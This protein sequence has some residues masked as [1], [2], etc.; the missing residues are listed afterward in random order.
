MKRLHDF[1]TW[2]K[3]NEAESSGLS[4]IFS[5]M[6]KSVGSGI[7]T[8]TS[9]F[10]DMFDKKPERVS[11]IFPGKEWETKAVNLLKKLGVV[12]GVFKSTEEAIQA[13]KALKNKG[14]KAKEL[15]IGSHGDG[16]TLLITQKEDTNAKKY[17]PELL[18]N[19][20]EII[21]KDSKV[22]FTAC[23]GADYLVNLVDSANS[24][25]VGVYGSRGIYNYITNSSENGYYYCKPY[26]IPKPKK[27][28]EPRDE[29]YSGKLEM[30]ESGYKKDDK[31]SLNISFFGPFGKEPKLKIEFNPASFSDLGW[32][33]K[34][35]E[36]LSF[37]VK[38]KIRADEEEYGTKDAKEIY[39]YEFYL[40]T[41]DFD[42]E[43]SLDEMGFTSLSELL[44][45]GKFRWPSAKRKNFAVKLKK[46]IEKGN[47]KLT[48]GD[49]D[50][51]KE[52][53]KMQG[54]RIDEVGFDNNEHLLEC[55]AC[56]KVSSAPI[57][58]ISPTGI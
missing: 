2:K 19:A 46:S 16:K 44:K 12:T 4:S 10:M 11:L 22:F 36:P 24:L 42:Y 49:V 27:V 17:A 28:T 14:V 55:G 33:L 6:T 43:R 57:S 37:I 30:K 7:S 31:D 32:Q 45:N 23:H 35:K 29:F 40:G 51:G 20:K 25:G 56:K 48:I 41:S 18:K 13:I 8:L 54:Y 3:I 38:E 47:V 15:V 52:R 5:N 58:W 34:S 9:K 21:N 1:N 50:L 26:K 53:P 39:E